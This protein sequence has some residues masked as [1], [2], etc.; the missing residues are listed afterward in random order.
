MR[1]WSSLRRLFFECYFLVAADVRSRAERC[2]D[3]PVRKLAGPERLSWY[4]VLQLR[5][6]CLLLEDDLEPS[7]AIVDY[8]SQM[9]E[10]EDSDCTVLGAQ[11][12]ELVSLPGPG[13][14]ISCCHDCG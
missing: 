2:E 6:K 13:L 9:I 5:L 14:G 4:D 12:Y 3:A 10:E 8:I 7:N 11:L 1:M